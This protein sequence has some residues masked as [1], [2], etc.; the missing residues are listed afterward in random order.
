MSNFSFS[1]FWLIFTA[2]V[3]LHA[4]CVGCT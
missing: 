4:Y 2:L 3:V 1:T